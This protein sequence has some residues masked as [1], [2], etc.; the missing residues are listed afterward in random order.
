M[1][2]ADAENMDFDSSFAGNEPHASDDMTDKQDDLASV[3]FEAELLKVN[4][5]TVKHMALQLED[6]LNGIRDTTKRLLTETDMYLTATARVQAEYTA[7]QDSQRAEAR[8]LDEVQPDV[9]GA[10][11][12]FLQE[13]QDQIASQ[14][15]ASLGASNQGDDVSATFANT[16][17]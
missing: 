2:P 11:L 7:C 14:M 1:D 13:A 10:T 8:R 6:I 17:Q 12:T 4:E 9:E 5:T 15:M 16:D 3:A